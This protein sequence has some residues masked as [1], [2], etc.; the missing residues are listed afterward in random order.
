MVTRVCH[1]VSGDLWAGAEVMVYQLLRGLSVRPE[2]E[3]CAIVLNEG[4]LSEEL[5]RT[6][7]EVCVLDE[8]KRSFADIARS[9]A[10]IVRQM[11]PQILHSHRYKENVLSY[12]IAR[13]LRRHP[14]LVSTLHGMPE[15]FGS[16]ATI[17][18][19]IKS[20]LNF[21]ILL[22]HFD[23]TVAVSSE[24]AN[25]LL[26]RL[27]F[28]QGTVDAIW[29]G[30]AI[31]S[32]EPNSG[33]RTG[34]RIGSAGRLVPV[35]GYDLMVEIARTVSARKPDI[36]FELAGEGPMLSEIRSTIN[37]CGLDSRFSLHGFVQDV[38][39]FYAGLDVYLNASKHEGIPMSVLEAMAAGLPAVVPKVGGLTEIIT[40][41]LEGFLVEGRNPE[42]F[43][44]RCLELYEDSCLRIRMGMAARERIVRCFSVDSMVDRYLGTYAQLIAARS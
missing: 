21:W 40:D 12:I 2:I 19:R 23:R 32:L 20:R 24:I 31:P 39:P 34:F 42:S 35:K 11:S 29:N 37:K 7:V 44:E 43:S 3:L 38:R 22:R 25:A 14:A 17:K 5:E 30:I 1:V 33:S 16:G 4:K 41:G 6:G 15:E 9:A 28:R 8:S 10:S 13:T 18:D 26:G 27:G 36:S